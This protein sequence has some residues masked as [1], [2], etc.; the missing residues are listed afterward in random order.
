MHDAPPISSLRK[1]AITG[2]GCAC[3]TPSLHFLFAYILGARPL[4]HGINFLVT[5]LDNPASKDSY[6]LSNRCLKISTLVFN[7]FKT[8]RQAF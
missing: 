4:L 8:L 7:Y 5:R 6:T 2:G 3:V 1:L